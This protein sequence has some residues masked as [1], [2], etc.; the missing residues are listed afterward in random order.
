MRQL[1]AEM[2]VSATKNTETDSLRKL[3][4]DMNFNDYVAGLYSLHNG[5][6]EMEYRQIVQK[7]K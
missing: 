7:E 4:A 1:V 3:A 5:F 6:A 2:M